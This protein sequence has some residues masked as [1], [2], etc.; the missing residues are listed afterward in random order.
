[1][2]HTTHPDWFEKEVRVRSHSIW[3]REGC[4]DGRDAANWAR[5][6]KEI[7]DECRAA[8]EGT[9]AYFTPPHLTISKLLTRH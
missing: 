1:M 6:A 3:E 9:N 8:A 5:A 4:N 2:S 7:E